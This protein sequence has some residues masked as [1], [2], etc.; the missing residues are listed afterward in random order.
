MY[1]KRA[2]V[3]D[4]GLCANSAEPKGLRD[5]LHKYSLEIREAKEVLDV[6]K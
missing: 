2:T 5:E 6:R 4:I 3:E 1:L